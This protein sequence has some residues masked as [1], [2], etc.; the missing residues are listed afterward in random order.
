MDLKLYHRLVAMALTEMCF[1][2]PMVTYL[3]AISTYYPWKGFEDLHYLFNRIDQF[4]YGEW[5]TIGKNRPDVF[6]WMEVGCGLIFF[7][8]LGF[9][10]SLNRSLYVKFFQMFKPFCITRSKREGSL[11]P[12]GAPSSLVFAQC[13]DN[14]AVQEYSTVI[15]TGT[16]V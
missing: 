9:T 11:Q 12:V 15:D 2:L 3:T 1:T 10:P 7:L 4:P 8:L 16:I 14:S 6:E 13:V 5:S